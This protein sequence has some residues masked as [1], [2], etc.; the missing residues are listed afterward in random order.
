MP[1]MQRI[2]GSGIALHAGPLPDYPASH[3]CI[4]LP[5]D[6]AVRLWGTTKVGARVIVTREPVATEG[7]RA[8]FH[9][10]LA[11]R[12]AGRVGQRT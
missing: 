11:G 4:R 5:Q 8:D 12:F 1:Y 7:D 10:S 2:T 3:G 9:P 6:F